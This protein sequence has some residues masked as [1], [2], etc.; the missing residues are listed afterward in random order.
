L[1][2]VG[3]RSLGS[4][5][6]SIRSPTAQLLHSVEKAVA[7]RPADDEFI[8]P[9]IPFRLELEPRD[10]LLPWLAKLAKRKP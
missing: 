8:K 10:V 6:S 9:L 4:G 2:G 5:T 3:R 1:R 7:A